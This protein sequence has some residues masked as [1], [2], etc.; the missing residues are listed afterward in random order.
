MPTFLLH[1]KCE[2]TVIGIPRLPV[3]TPSPRQNPTQTLRTLPNLAQKPHLPVVGTPAHTGP[4]RVRSANR[5]NLCRADLVNLARATGVLTVIFRRRGS[6]IMRRL[7]IV[8]EKTL[9]QQSCFRWPPLLAPP[10][11]GRRFGTAVIRPNGAL[12]S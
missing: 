4:S 11:V 10:G 7:A 5:E 8:V 9:K 6:D 2:L 1:M 12:Y 3:R